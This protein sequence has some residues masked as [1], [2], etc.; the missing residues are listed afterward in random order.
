MAV[1]ITSLQCTLTYK[2]TH[3]TVQ[4]TSIDV[5]VNIQY[6]ARKCRLTHYATTECSSLKLCNNFL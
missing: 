5:S 3:E 6:H 1:F 2:A 4:Q